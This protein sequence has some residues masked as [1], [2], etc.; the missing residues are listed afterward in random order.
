M[1][2]GPEGR[3]AVL[4][5][6]Q[7]ERNSAASRVQGTPCEGGKLEP[8]ARGQEDVGGEEEE[9]GG[10]REENGPRE[11]LDK[12]GLREEVEGGG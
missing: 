6:L 9:R 4:H 12:G 10:G 2:Q 8:G 3:E 11:P 1:D 7:Q 5:R